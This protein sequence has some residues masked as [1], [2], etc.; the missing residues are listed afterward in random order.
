MPAGFQYVFSKNMPE[1]RTLILDR[2]YRARLTRRQV[3]GGTGAVLALL[4]GIWTLTPLRPQ[5]QLRAALRALP[6]PRPPA[7]L[8]L[9]KFDNQG[10]DITILVHLTWQPGQRQRKFAAHES[11]VEQ[12]VEALVKDVEAWVDQLV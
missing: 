9:V 11:T 2:P 8:A 12:S 1:T 5:D 4:A 10:P 6:L 3:L 7:R